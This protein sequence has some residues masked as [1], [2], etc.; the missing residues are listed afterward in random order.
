MYFVLTEGR[1]KAQIGKLNRK[2]LD[3]AVDI[4]SPFVGN[5]GARSK[6]KRKWLSSSTK[7]TQEEKFLPEMKLLAFLLM[8]VVLRRSKCM[9]F[10]SN[11]RTVTRLVFKFRFKVTGMTNIHN[12]S[13]CFMKVKSFR[14][15]EVFLNLTEQL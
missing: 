11:C 13:E 5:P 8:S 1:P 6:Q 2:L 14:Q 12:A 10:L 3:A 15:S 9:N 4:S 7:F